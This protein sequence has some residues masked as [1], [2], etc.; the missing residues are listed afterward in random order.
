MKICN[1]NT[2]VE[3]CGCGEVVLFLHGWGSSHLDFAGT[4]KIV[5]RTMRVINIDLWGF[6]KSEEPCSDFLSDDYAD[7]VYELLKKL[8]IKKVHLVGHSFG[9]KIATKLCVKFPDFVKSLILVDSA[10]LQK[11]LSFFVKK[12]MKRYKKLKILVFQGK[13]DSNVLE[14]FGSEDYKNSSQTM[15]K[16]M[17]K[18]VNESCEQDFAKV[19]VPTLIFWG[20]KDK[21]TPLY[22]GKR[23]NQL[24]K[25]SKFVIL[26][27]GHFSHIDDFEKFNKLC[28]EFW[29]SI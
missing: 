1:L 27:G 26:N 28:F 20:K 21:D 23:I 3:D 9:G 10:G 13:K 8:K 29:R 17:V 7:M 14:K 12:R 22:M 24:I 25:N 6:G 19:N 16:I 5:Q 15:R 2:Y 4:S 11:K 18:V